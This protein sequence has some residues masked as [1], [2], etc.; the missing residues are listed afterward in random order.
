MYSAK[1]LNRE[2][3]APG[4]LKE[5]DSKSLNISNC[6]RLFAGV[7]HRQELCGKPEKGTEDRRSL[8]ASVLTPALQFNVVRKY[9]FDSEK[10]G[11]QASSGSQNYQEKTQRP[12]K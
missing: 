1:D 12:F 7:C 2:N 3:T 11:V 8:T 4:H 6:P 10:G 9:C 5:E